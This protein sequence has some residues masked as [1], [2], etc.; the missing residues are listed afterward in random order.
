MESG[1]VFGRFAGRTIMNSEWSV[2]VALLYA[3]L[4]KGGIAHACQT[5]L[6]KRYHTP[7]V[8]IAE[9][10]GDGALSS[11]P[12]DR[13]SVQLGRR[14]NGVICCLSSFVNTTWDNRLF[15]YAETAI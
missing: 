10:A 15:N 7:L 4:V 12:N 9:K 1:D 13:R 8:K 5:F 2:L 3:T 14:G 11:I 6:G